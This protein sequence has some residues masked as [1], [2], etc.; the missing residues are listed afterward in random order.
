[1]CG[2]VGYT[3]P[4]GDAENVVKNMLDSIK[5]RGPD[6]SG[7]YISELIAFGHVRLSVVDLEGGQQPRVC[8]HS[9][10][11]LVY[12]GEIYSYNKHIDKL[13]LDGVVLEDDSDTEVLF[14]YLQKYKIEEVLYNIDGMYSFAYFD[15][16]NKTLILARD[17]YGEKPLFYAICGRNI[18]F[19]SELSALRRHPLLNKREFKPCDVSKFL[20]FEY[21]P[22]DSTGIEGIKKLPP[23]NILTWSDGKYRIKSYWKPVPPKKIIQIQE[24]AE[25]EKTKIDTLDKLLSDSVKERLVAD[26]PV[27]VFLS[28]GIDS[29]LIAAYAKKYATD[30]SAFTVKM[31]G[32]TYD[33]S[34]YARKVARHLDIKHYLVELGEDDLISAFDAVFD[35]L[36]DLNADPSLVPTYLVCRAA[37]EH[38]T[39]ALGG[40]GA[41]ELFAGY[42]NFFVQQYAGI[43]SLFPDCFA[44]LLRY[45]I[46]NLP[47]QTGYMNLGYKLRQLSYGFGKQ[48]NN[49]SFYWMASFSPDEQKNLWVDKAISADV[50]NQGTDLINN[51]T[52]ELHRSDSLFT[53]LY[54]FTRTYL[55]DDILTKV[56]RTSMYNSL[57]VRAP[58]LAKDFSE[59]V[60][61]L[62]SRDKLRGKEGKYLLKKLAERYLP[63]EI[64]YRKKHGFAIAVDELIRTKLKTRFEDVIFDESNPIVHWFNRKYIYNLWHEHI[65]N[66]RDHRK[67]LWTLYTL[68]RVAAN[69]YNSV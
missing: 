55:P 22:G 13:R 14:A 41:D 8:R 26:V 43:M 6:Q 16:K 63:N 32:A 46:D 49:Q 52:H 33:E 34:E 25:N 67:K 39:V 68:L 3:S 54:L 65:S 56:D 1:M 66:K 60:L 40:D 19:A 69:K 45:V 4:N 2:F 51:F 12:N 23:G 17:R 24:S 50:E 36:S 44:R 15:S 10:N 61:S 57:E 58:F 28:G 11:T 7:K 29:S 37:R 35:N 42:P 47:H 30:I 59:Y 62:N 31:C 20:W 9:G 64:I 27:G 38:V 18:V 21:L 53:L 5:Y 48:G